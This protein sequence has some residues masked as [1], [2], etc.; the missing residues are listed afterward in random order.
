ML[1]HTL[2]SKTEYILGRFFS[3]ILVR[4]KGDNQFLFVCF[5][6]S[7]RLDASDFSTAS[8]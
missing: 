5:L 1:N 7:I 4:F 8:G 3:I 6:I 2:A